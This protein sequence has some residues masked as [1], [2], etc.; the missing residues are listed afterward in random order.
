ME[1]KGRYPAL[2]LPVLLLL[3]LAWW[4]VLG[5]YET[6]SFAFRPDGI[7]AFDLF[8]F[9]AWSHPEP[10][11]L[12]TI[13]YGRARSYAN[14]LYQD[15]DHDGHEEVAF[16]TNS[17]DRGHP[18]RIVI[19]NNRGKSLLD[20]VVFDETPV[21][22]LSGAGRFL[23]YFLTGIIPGTKNN[24]IMVL[25][26]RAD[27][28]A[29]EYW[30]FVRPSGEVV[31]RYHSRGYGSSPCFF[32]IDDDGIPEMVVGVIHNGWERVSVYAVKPIGAKGFSP[33]GP[34]DSVSYPIWLS[35]P[36][37]NQLVYY[38]L[39]HS[40]VCKANGLPYPEPWL[41][42]EDQGGINVHTCE[43]KLA[44]QLPYCTAD[45]TWVFSR[46]LRKFDRLLVTDN[47]WG[48]SQKIIPETTDRDSLTHALEGQVLRWSGTTW[49]P[50]K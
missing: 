41:I 39:P 44:P 22:S 18:G 48:V 40:S 17:P 7:Q 31:G 36:P 27:S 42:T 46:D 2:V 8:G 25:C 50:A 49:V 28:P 32:D 33:P 6:L 3:A 16:V 9:Q 14:W 20:T 23:H 47:Y 26:T 12:D 21:D 13:Q 29:R 35:Q 11:G 38:I 1:G 15:L 24:P 43:E 30:V 4:L 45:L 37:G 34:K 5:R 10:A 19:L